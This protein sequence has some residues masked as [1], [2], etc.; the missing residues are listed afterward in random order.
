MSA[1]RA[2]ARLGRAAREGAKMR[3]RQ[4]LRV[5]HAVVPGGAAPSGHLLRVLREELNVKEVRFLHGAD[6]LVTL[7]AQPNFRTLGRRFGGRTQEAASRIR[8]LSADALHE[9]RRGGTL[10]IEVGGETFAIGAGELEVV[11]DAKGELV[12]ESGDGYTV[13]LDLEVDEA[14]RLEGLAR[15]LVNRIQRLRRETGLQ[16]AD[17]IRLEIAGDA[18]VRAAVAAQ[19]E[20]IAGETLA[21]AIA[22]GEE[23]VSGTVHEVD[24]DGRPVRI[25]LKRE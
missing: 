12:I 24:L 2:L 23:I 7:R 14:L 22:V 6:E 10:S 5:M 18:E 17:R 20:Y 13:A 16:V 1:V 4:P 15:E 21:V 9:F 3:V 8:E 25:S 19:G 11:E